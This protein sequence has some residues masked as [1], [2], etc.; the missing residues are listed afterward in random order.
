MNMQDFLNRFGPPVQSQRLETN[1]AERFRGKVPDDLLNFWHIHGLG[2]YADGLYHLCTPDLFEPLL[3]TLL[4]PVAML[5]GKLHAVG[6][7]CFGT[8]DLWHEE[9]R[10]FSLFV[11]F[12]AFTDQSSRRE[13]EPPPHDIAALYAL[14][15]VEMPSSAQERARQMTIG[16][17]TI[18]DELAIG[19]SLET[20]RN[21]FGADGLP[22]ASEVRQLLGPTLPDEI[23]LLRELGLVNIASSFEKVAIASLSEHILSDTVS[24]TDFV[25]ADGLQDAR[26]ELF[27]LGPR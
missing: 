22:L 24:V 21:D 2:S 7:S 16:P 23:Y 9:G 3:S 6:Y 18:W 14:A 20:Y 15:D 8:V 13:S 25:L 10:H 1:V 27:A 17:L 11:Q 12:A 19:A 26:T 4:A 5:D